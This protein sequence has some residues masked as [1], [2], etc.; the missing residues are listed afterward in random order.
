LYGEYVE[1]SIFLLSCILPPLQKD[2]IDPEN[3]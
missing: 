2:H 1:W 3:G